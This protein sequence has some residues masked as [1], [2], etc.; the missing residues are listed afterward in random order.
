MSRRAAA[1]AG[2]I[3]AAALA[4]AGCNADDEPTTKAPAPFTSVPAPAAPSSA[5]ASSAPANG[6]ASG[7]QANVKRGAEAGEPGVDVLV[8]VDYRG[9]KVT[10]PA[11]V[12]DVQVGEHVKITV[13]SDT[14]QNIDVQG[15]P[16]ES[17]DVAPD[18]PEDV[19]WTVAKPGDTRVTLRESGALL[20]TLHAS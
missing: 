20:T 5:P 2:T 18:E 3:A 11:G 16:D 12:V 7:E 8:T 15:Q 10:P 6:S 9:G 1:L 19:D 13:R 14:A 17:A 4:V